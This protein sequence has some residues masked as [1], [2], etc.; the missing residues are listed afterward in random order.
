MGA[1][2]TN[3]D[4]VAGSFGVP[5]RIQQIVQRFKPPAIEIDDMPF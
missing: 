2:V 3:N 1:A 4:Q 5:G